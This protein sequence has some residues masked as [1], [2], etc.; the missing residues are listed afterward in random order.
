MKKISAKH[1]I[2]ID[3]KEV[4]KD[5]NR[6]DLTPEQRI[7]ID[8]ISLAVAGVHYTEIGE[9]Y[10]LHRATI[11]E[12]LHYYKKEGLEGLKRPIKPIIKNAIDAEILRGYLQ[13]SSENDKIKLTALIELAETKNTNQ[14]AKN[15]QVTPQ[16][17]LKWKRNFL[18]GELPASQAF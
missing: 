13:G 18:S 6:T 5:H 14:T 1:R 15:H 16:G 12:W 9:K 2:D 3:Y 4:V 11:T 17:L 8:V 7:R 10:N